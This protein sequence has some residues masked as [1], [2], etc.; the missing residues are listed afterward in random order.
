MSEKLCINSIA[1]AKGI[2]NST[3]GGGI[4]A[5]DGVLYVVVGFGFVYAI[6]SS[7]GDIIWKRNI[8]V[9]LRGSPTLGNGKVFFISILNQT[10]AL[11]K[12]DGNIIWVHS[13]VPE[14]TSFLGGTSPALYNKTLLSPY[15]SGEVYALDTNSGRVLWNKKLVKARSR[16]S[17]VKLNDIHSRPIIDGRKVY[18]SG[19]GGKLMSVDIN[20]G[21]NIWSREF[22]IIIM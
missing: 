1:T 20:T 10:Y 12:K 16:L 8:S 4:A 15:S 13:G 18:L 3:S 14:I 17:L 7:N 22:S 2:A 9:P 5:E 21:S 6:N 11:D 19:S